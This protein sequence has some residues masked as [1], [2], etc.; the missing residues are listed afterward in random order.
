[1]GINKGYKFTE[2][3]LNAIFL[4]V[5]KSFIQTGT[6]RFQSSRDFWQTFNVEDMCIQ[7]RP[8]GKIMQYPQLYLM[9]HHLSTLSP[10]HMP[11]YTYPET[12]LSLPTQG[13][14]PSPHTPALALTLSHNTVFYLNTRY[15]VIFKP[16]WH[17]TNQ[18]KVFLNIHVLNSFLVNIFEIEW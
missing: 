15:P 10:S 16:I 3:G 5:K 13:F 2:L 1:M 18:A 4:W 14:Q 12:H 17:N 8:Q 6:Q 11:R 9:T 7:G